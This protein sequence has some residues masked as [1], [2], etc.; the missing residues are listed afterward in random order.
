M[1]ALGGLDGLSFRDLAIAAT[2]GSAPKFL[3]SDPLREYLDRMGLKFP[4]VS[5]T[6]DGGLAIA[7]VIVERKH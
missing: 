6:H 3:A 2:D 5:L 4:R 1:K 7:F